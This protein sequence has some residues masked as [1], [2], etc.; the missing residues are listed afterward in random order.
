MLIQGAFMHMDD[1]LT[2]DQFMSFISCEAPGGHYFV[3]QPPPGIVMTAAVDWRVILPDGDSIDALAAA[4]WSGYESLVRPLQKKSS[5]SSPGIYIQIKN[6][7]GEWD[8]FTLGKDVV[9]RDKFVHRVRESVAVLAPKNKESSLRLEIEKT[10][11][12]DYWL[13]V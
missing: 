1:A 2:A 12:S 10:M 4:L 11:G 6:L 3:A 7:R 9:Q 8:H 13:E 5:E